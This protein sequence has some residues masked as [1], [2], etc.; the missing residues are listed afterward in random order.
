MNVDGSWTPTYWPL[1]TADGR[2]YLTLN[3]NTSSTGKGPRIRP[4]VF[5]K[6][7]LPQLIET[8]G[9]VCSIHLII[10]QIIVVTVSSRKIS[11]KAQ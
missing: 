11:E 5:W 8:A 10:I 1:H 7:Y 2:E 6:Q 9:K 4:C 3:V